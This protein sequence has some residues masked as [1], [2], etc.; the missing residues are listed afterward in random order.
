MRQLRLVG[1]VAA[2]IV[3]ALQADAMAAPTGSVCDN[4]KPPPLRDTRLLSWCHVDASNGK[5]RIWWRKGSARAERAATVAFAALDG[6]A[7]QRLVSYFGGKEPVPDDVDD[8][9]RSCRTAASR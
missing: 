7:W 2:V 9:A 4:G 1:C 8:Q 6:G 5:L 3:V